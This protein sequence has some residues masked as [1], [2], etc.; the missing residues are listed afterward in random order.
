M[1]AGPLTAANW[2]VSTRQDGEVLAVWAGSEDLQLGV[3]S[4]REGFSPVELDGW[5]RDL[6]N[7][8]EESARQDVTARD[9]PPL[10]HHA[11]T[12]LLF[13][14]A[15]LWEREGGLYFST[16]LISVEGLTGIG[17]VG[18][19][20]LQVHVDGIP[21]EI[22]WVVVRDAEGREGRAATFDAALPLRI[23]ISWNPGMAEDCGVAMD[24]EWSPEPLAAGDAAAPGGARVIELTADDLAPML[25]EPAVEEV[26]EEIVAEA[27]AELAVP[28]RSEIAEPGP[29]AAE[30]E[31]TGWEAAR[32]EAPPADVQAPEPEVW[33]ASTEVPAALGVTEAGDAA[34]TQAPA[35]AAWME[36][37]PIAN[38]GAASEPQ[39]SEIGDDLV[40]DRQEF[41]PPERRELSAVAKAFDLD[42]FAESAFDDA[43][44]V[45]PD[46]EAKEES[47][48][49]AAP[50]ELGSR[51]SPPSAARGNGSAVED[52]VDAPPP[53][54][55]AELPAPGLAEPEPQPEAAEPE[56]RPKLEANEPQ[57]EAEVAEVH[58]ADSAQTPEAKIAEVLKA[59][60]AE[61]APAAEVEPVAAADAESVAPA[62]AEP[63]VDT[64]AEISESGVT[65]EARAPEEAPIAEPAE[66]A[67]GQVEAAP[68]AIAAPD[69]EAA[70]PAAK[71]PGLWERV[72]S[73]WKRR[74]KRATESDAGQVD[75]DSVTE[76]AREQASEPEAG[77]P[78]APA[79]SRRRGAAL[80]ARDSKAD[81]NA[82]QAEAD[83]SAH[84]A[85]PGSSAAAPSEP[86]ALKPKSISVKAPSGDD[87]PRIAP[88]P[89]AAGAPPTASASRAPEDDG[90][91]IQRRGD[92]LAQGG[93]SAASSGPPLIMPR[94]QAV[95]PGDPPKAMRPASLSPPPLL[96]PGATRPSSAPEPPSTPGEHEAPGDE[97]PKPPALPEER[98]APIARTSPERPSLRVT[99]EVPAEAEPETPAQPRRRPGEIPRVVR[100]GAVPRPG[101]RAAPPAAT[102]L[103]DVA[104]DARPK[105]AATP[106]PE[107]VESAAHP[108]PVASAEP[109]PA[110]PAEAEKPAPRRSEPRP[111]APA[112]QPGTE[113]AAAAAPA[114]APARAPIR[115]QW[116]SEEEM[117]PPLVRVVRTLFGLLLVA[118]LF[119]AGWLLGGLAPTRNDKSLTVNPFLEVIQG[120]S[121]AAGR[122]HVAVTT[123]PDGASVAVDGK[124][125]GKLSPATID[126]KPGAHQ[127]TLSFPG[128]GSAT[129]GVRGSR[130]QNVTL[131]EALWGRLTVEQDNPDVPISVSIDG[132]DHGF[133]PVTIDSVAPGAHEVRFSAPNMTPW[134]Q[135][136]A[137]KVRES[138]RIVAHPMTSPATGV[139]SIRATLNGAQG[140]TALNG[141][142]VWLDGELVGRTP[143][144]LELPR[145]PHSVKVVYGQDAAA[146]QV[147]DLP[148]GNQRFAAF[149]LG[150]SGPD[151]RLTPASV[152]TKVLPD[153]P[154]LVSAGMDGVNVSDVRE[155]WLHVRGPDDNW[156]RYQLNVMK[157]PSGVV[158]VT[159]FPL[160]VFDDNGLTKYYL[161]ALLITGDEYFTEITSARLVNGQG[162]GASN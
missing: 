77:A 116:P 123:E 139:L 95:A 13:S 131:H 111:E 115:A 107:H 70:P 81:A 8:A 49:A 24:A 64:A 55:V 20:D 85:E 126:L 96:K 74:G 42:R 105:P 109:I 34:E 153:Q 10:L 37:E 52:D 30:P 59:L 29:E 35:D 71:R 162:G 91:I 113:A 128:L 7:V 143:L 104:P 78:I 146:V 27:A 135:T 108:E 61:L 124:D 39:P 60:E 47:A 18:E 88:L 51:W 125:A 149:Q 26:D 120:F 66:P 72:A 138:A 147:I 155:M 73:L 62:E 15:E 100:P 16:A 63:A 102:P 98:L 58:E 150:G 45:A 121:F 136:V 89:S 141:G 129:F 84:E 53:R 14:H 31:A 41:T 38:E 97:A 110:A 2:T 23:W 22:D 114:R 33:A 112:A 36:E 144:T 134:A 1:G 83:A 40:R 117:T 101:K 79:R 130:D 157:T 158:G 99:P 103:P 17:W 67:S 50:I 80:V 140:G 76:A 75:L 87:G 12:G 92:P 94:D 6:V 56:P 82:H 148:G 48:E 122:Y 43:L 118:A 9:I 69:E 156:R 32:E 5:L 137:V 119:L 161:S 25:E 90:L 151:L 160:G 54:A 28:D 65:L 57:P 4:T 142:E 106:A 11:L 133:A 132:V 46:H 68:E 93:T 86:P 154:A 159:T 145:G 44:E 3:F 19:A 127:V 152:V 21:Q